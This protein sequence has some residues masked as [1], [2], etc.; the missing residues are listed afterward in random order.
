MYIHF[1]PN[2]KYNE[3]NSSWPKGDCVI[4]AIACAMNWTWHQSFTYCV[5]H[6]MKAGDLPNA[7]EGFRQIMQDLNF[8]RAILDEKYKINVEKFCN[9]N[10]VGTYILSVE[11][12]SGHVVCCKN[13]NWY[14]AFDSGKFLVYGYNKL[15]KK[16][17]Y[18]RKLPYIIKLKLH[19]HKIFKKI[20][21]KV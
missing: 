17:P 12:I 1:N 11:G 19:F 10:P 20:M 9:Q 16:Q 21:K 13:G 4:R 8:E 2:P 15:T 3:E 6:S 14:D 18:I 5:T 7:L